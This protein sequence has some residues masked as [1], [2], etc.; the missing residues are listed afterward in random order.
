MRRLIEGPYIGSWTCFG[1]PVDEIPSQ[2]LIVSPWTAVGET[3]S[4][5]LGLCALQ[6]VV[7]EAFVFKS[8]LSF[9]G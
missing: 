9:L 2:Y 1:E 8:R 4:N 5:G 6:K 3:E 7:T